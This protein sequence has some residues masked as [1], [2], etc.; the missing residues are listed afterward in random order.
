MVLRILSENDGFNVEDKYMWLSVPLY[1]ALIY[2][3]SLEKEFWKLVKTNGD[4]NEFDWCIAQLDDANK[5]SPGSTLNLLKINSF[6]DME[7]R[8]IWSKKIKKSVLEESSYFSNDDYWANAIYLIKTIRDNVVHA[9]YDEVQKIQKF[10]CFSE[11]GDTIMK[12]AFSTIISLIAEICAYNFETNPSP[13][14]S[15]ADK[16]S[17]DFVRK[18]NFWIK[19]SAVWG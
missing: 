18:F 10:L 9:N 14:N 11:K 1:Q 2:S 4:T 8:E 7:T 6:K 17:K 16:F 3:M 15:S 19:G 12:S 5:F 13:E